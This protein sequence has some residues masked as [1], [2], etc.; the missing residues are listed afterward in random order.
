MR[1]IGQIIAVS[2]V[3][4]A[5]HA[6]ASDWCYLD[7]VEKNGDGVIAHFEEEGHYVNLISARGCRTFYTSQKPLPNY[8]PNTSFAKTIPAS[9]GDRYGMILSPEISC[10]L[11][12]VVH[13]GQ[14][15]LEAQE[16]TLVIKSSGSIRR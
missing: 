2:V 3:L 16:S 12:V 10:G 14:I 5:G 7:Y 13:D 11:N 6:Y 1:M 4:G 15:G 9:L 8:P